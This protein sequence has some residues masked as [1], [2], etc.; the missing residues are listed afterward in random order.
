MFFLFFFV[1]VGGVGWEEGGLCVFSFEW[2][3]QIHS[4]EDH[5]VFFNVKTSLKT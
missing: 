4:S 1:G 2:P 3:H 5:K